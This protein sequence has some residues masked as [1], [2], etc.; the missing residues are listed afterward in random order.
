MCNC[1]PSGATAR[2]PVGEL[3]PAAAAALGRVPGRQCGD[4]RAGA[5][6][7]GAIHVHGVALYRLDGVHDFCSRRWSALDGRAPL[8][9]SFLHDGRFEVGILPRILSVLLSLLCNICS[10]V[11]CFSDRRKLDQR[12]RVLIDHTKA[13]IR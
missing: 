6:R 3:E 5:R 4:V 9:R 1:R 13:A 12:S 2:A 7:L 10:I 11:G 8:S